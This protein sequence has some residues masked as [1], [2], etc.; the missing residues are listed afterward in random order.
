MDVKEMNEKGFYLKFRAIPI[1][2]APFLKNSRLKSSIFILLLLGALLLGL[3]CFNAL[4]LTMS[5]QQKML[6]ELSI[7][8]IQGSSKPQIF[9]L[10][11]QDAI[12]QFLLS[13]FIAFIVLQIIAPLV[14]ANFRIDLWSA[15]N[16]AP[17]LALFLAITGILFVA[18][19]IIPGQWSL[20]KISQQKHKLIRKKDSILTDIPLAFQV[21]ISFTLL[22]F[23]WFIFKQLDYI[24]N[25]DK[26]YESKN[27]AYIQLNNKQLFS[28]DKILKRELSSIPGVESVGL[29]DDIPLYG[30]SGNNFGPESDGSKHRNFRNLRAD[31][32]FFS[33]LGIDVQGTGFTETANQGNKVIISESVAKDLGLED[34]INQTIYRNFGQPFIIAGIIPDL[35]YGTLHSG[36]QGVVFNYYDEPDV[37][38][39]L[40]FSLDPNNTEKTL[41]AIKN[42][43]AEIVPGTIPQVK[44]YDAELMASYQLDYAIRKAIIFFAIIAVLLTISGIVGYSINSI[45]KRIKEIGVRKVNGASEWSLLQL[46]NR[47]FIIKSIIS[48]LL[49]APV[50]W[51]LTNTWIQNYAYH[52][53]I[54]PVVFGVLSLVIVMVVFTTITL[55]VLENVRKNPVEALR[56]E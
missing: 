21:G 52:I 30:L 36:K 18:I 56:Y 42:K 46:L 43:V 22:V 1:T 55:A 32:E 25:F 34:P 27:V 12:F 24:Q 29:S 14:M 6:K 47:S 3:V 35:I 23:F 45:Q 5:Q 7:R 38:S 11:L 19:F 10:L 39:T 26:G 28:K 54:S 13:I 4:L 41:K 2:E 15:I 37:Y 49:F 9:K 50:S 53:D 48:L 31:M 20:R 40:T 33:T 17:F 44:F 16:T 8:R 51:W